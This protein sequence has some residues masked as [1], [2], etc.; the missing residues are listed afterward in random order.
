MWYV[1][2]ETNNAIAAQLGVNEK[3]MNYILALLLP[4]VT[5]GIVPLVWMY[6]FMR[7]QAAIAK[8]AGVKTSPSESPLIL[9]ILCCVPIYSI[10]M[11]CNNY[12][13][14]VD[15]ATAKA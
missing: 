15:A 11:L 4:A 8:A 9:L 13:T 10:Y 5:C 3:R 1:M 2:T 6:R 14:T 12:N 7:Q